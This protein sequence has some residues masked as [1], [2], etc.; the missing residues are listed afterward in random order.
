[1]RALNVRH[2]RSWSD[3]ERRAF[4]ELAPAISLIPGLGTWA[5]KKK[6]D[7]VGLMRAKGRMREDRY[8]NAL[9]NHDLLLRS[10]KKILDDMQ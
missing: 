3:D 9:R 5:P 10:W 6:I 1:M 2:A 8:I 4:E 7:L